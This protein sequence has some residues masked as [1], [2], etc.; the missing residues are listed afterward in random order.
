MNVTNIDFFQVLHE[1]HF[2]SMHKVSLHLK[3][4][5]YNKNI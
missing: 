2:Y 3:R 5:Y 1:L 4:L